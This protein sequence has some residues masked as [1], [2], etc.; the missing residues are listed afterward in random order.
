MDLVKRPCLEGRNELALVDQTV[1]Q[2]DQSEQE[3]SVRG[4]VHVEAPRHCVAP[5]ASDGGNGATS[6]GER[7][8]CA[9]ISYGAAGP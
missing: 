5:G 4:A 1:L 8:E 6:R 9:I 7:L 2:G 3:M